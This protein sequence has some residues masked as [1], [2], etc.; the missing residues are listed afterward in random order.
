M[1]K[2]LCIVVLLCFLQNPLHAEI[3]NTALLTQSDLEQVSQLAGLDLL[4]SNILESL[5]KKVFMLSDCNNVSD[6][7]A[8][9][10]FMSRL[11]LATLKENKNFVL[12]GAIASNAF[13]ADPMLDKIRQ[14]RNNN[15]FADSIPKGSLIAPQYSIS[16][17][18]SS[19]MRL[20][21]G[22]YIVEYHFIFTLLDLKTGLV[23]WDFTHSITKLSKELPSESLESQY[24]IACNNAQ[25]IGNSSPREVCEIAISELWEGNVQDITESRRGLILSY[26]QKAVK[27]ESIFG[28]RA[29]ASL[30]RFGVG[31]KQDMQKALQL[32]SKA[33][34]SNDSGSCYNLALMA[35]NAQGMKQDIVQ[36]RA[37]ANK[38]CDLQM[39]AGCRL[40]ETLEKAKATGE[41]NERVLELQGRCEKNIP[42]ACNDL[43]F[44]YYHGLNGVAKNDALATELMQ[45]ACR[46]GGIGGCYQLGLWYSGG[47]GGLQKSNQKA[48]EHFVKSCDELQVKGAC[49]DSSFTQCQSNEQ[50]YKSVACQTIGAFYEQGGTDL[51]Q[52]TSKALKY[53]QKACDMGLELACRNFE[54]LKA[55]MQ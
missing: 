21:K 7:N 4:Q 22:V 18:L 51:P 17:R 30:Y 16:M 13:N 24:G 35:Q 28:L 1:K 38:A 40:L 36:A 49:K 41:L 31:V 43:S 23:E 33:C 12:S 44:S 29:M 25:S 39:N 48:I 37:Y 8:D 55:K 3:Q 52:N 9:M 46:L 42:S 32:Y 2:S 6:F 54:S 10:P 11:F 47:Y 34:E 50:N 26:A 15:E 53:Y 14:M 5:G 20:Q 45:K 27:L 19:N